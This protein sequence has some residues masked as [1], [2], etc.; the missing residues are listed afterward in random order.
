MDILLSNP[1]ALAVVIAGALLVL[2][3]IW[4]ILKGLLKITVMSV[5]IAVIALAVFRLNTLGLLPF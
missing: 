4:K 1:V 2:I 3:L 5:L